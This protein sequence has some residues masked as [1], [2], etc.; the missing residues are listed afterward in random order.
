MDV[1]TAL[2]SRKSVR[3]FAP[4]HVP[5]DLIEKILDGA[6]HA[7][8]GSNMQPWVV[9]I[10]TGTVRDAI[11]AEASA[12][13]AAGAAD[14]AD[15]TYYPKPILEPWL[16]RRRDCGWGLYAHMGVRK[17]DR[18]ASASIEARNFDFFGAPVALFFYL[19]RSLARGSWVDCGMFIQSV[20]LMAQSLGMAT[21]PQASWLHRQAIVSRHLSV[22][23]NEVMVCG[24]ALGFAEPEAHA[25]RYQ[26]ARLPV[27][28]FANWY[29]F[30][31]EQV[32]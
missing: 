6:R 32:P 8:S 23:A 31:D 7:P 2:R 11:A 13:F 30:A 3:A 5:R 29:G 14:E 27:E 25:N 20:M 1:S 19:D 28:S 4:N 12:A 21:C 22:P 18:A 26:P 16:S 10:A 17:G 9:R 15:W 24:M